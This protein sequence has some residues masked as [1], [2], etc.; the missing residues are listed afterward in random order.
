MVERIRNAYQSLSEHPFVNGVLPHLLTVAGFLLALFVIARL[1][2]ERKQ[3]GNT[4]AWLL[5][6]AFI[7]YVGVPL[8][9]LLGGRKIKRL[10][11]RKTR[12][13]PRLS[14]TVASS[15]AMGPTAR[16]VNRDGV[17]PPVG[18][19]R[20]RFLTTGEDAYH[21]L[22]RRIKEARHTIH[23]TTFL[24]AR[25]EVGRRLV[26]LLAK[27]AC[28]GVKVRLLLDALGC[29][30]SSRGFVDPIRKAGG[31]VYRFMPMLP[32][33]P[34]RSANLRN[35]RKIAVVDHQ[36]AILGGHNLAKEYMGPTPLR[37][38]W[39]DFGAV[40]EGPAV[41]LLNEIFLADWAFASEQSI[42]VLHKR[43]PPLSVPAAGMSELQ[44][45]AS[46]PDVEGDPLYEGILSAIQEAGQR[47]WIVTPYFIPDEVL[48]RTLLL[49]VRSG[50]EVRIV[51]PA[52]S[53]HP[54]TDFAR[55]HYLR[56]LAAAGAQILFYTPTMNHAKLIL[57]D[58]RI[59]LIGSANLDL[60]SLFVNFEVG[61]FIYSPSDCAAL[62]NWV[63]E[64]FSRC[65]PMPLTRMK[66]RRFFTTL[67][68]DISRLLAPL[69]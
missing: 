52:R 64:V 4:V 26:S 17:C 42:D 40:I 60:R 11:A 22:E 13:C 8:Y 67:G 57:V 54:V 46:G 37:R 47:V 65:K 56:E 25:D 29:F 50:V 21:E 12:L 53:N 3:P 35:H 16:I 44:V 33:Q 48:F 2:S 39:R 59:G 38:R 28:E 9:L 24:L 20:V 15:A 32:L 1:M 68:E 27:R 61:V 66:R 36:L 14:D 69:L 30:R 62:A 41:N 18:G 51:V 10:A 58:E 6:I 43:L 34:R 45:V 5:L 55:R 31:E 7:P 23:L 63:R 49:K 19:N